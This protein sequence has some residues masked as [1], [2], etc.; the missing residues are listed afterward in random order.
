MY[1]VVMNILYYPILSKL[2][3]IYL[4]GKVFDNCRCRKREK[5]LIAFSGFM[6]GRLITRVYS[7]P[8]TKPSCQRSPG[9][10]LYIQLVNAG[11]VAKIGHLL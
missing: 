7:I 9:S 8:E 3:P 11:F 2:A 10:V 5:S 4:F 1:F 6:S